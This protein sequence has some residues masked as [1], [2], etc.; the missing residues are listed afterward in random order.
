VSVRTA[1][2]FPGQGSDPG[3]AFALVD[4]HLPELAEAAC[5]EAGADVF[6]RAGDCMGYAQPAIYLASLAGWRELREAHGDA[7]L[8]QDGIAFAGHSLGEITALAAAGALDLQDGLRLVALRGALMDAGSR[9][10]ARGGMLALLGPG[11]YAVASA[12]RAQG[13]SIANDNSPLQVVVSGRRPALERFAEIAREA[14]LRTVGLPMN[15]AGHCTLM[16]MIAQRFR[17]ALQQV[18]FRQ[19]DVPVWSSATAAPF[20]RPGEELADAIVRTVRWRELVERM[21]GLG[22]RRFLETGPGH[23]LSR[24]V[25]ATLDGIE[26]RAV[27]QLTA[28]V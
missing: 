9:G 1:V 19:P 27:D 13:I 16:G 11:A 18:R 26:S 22:A 3:Q 28:D 7:E 15:V 10:A 17:I 12:G 24:L 4:R 21:H 23:V 2:I 25:S 14:G 5:A 8:G 6:A 20:L